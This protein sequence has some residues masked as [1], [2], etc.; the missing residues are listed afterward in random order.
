MKKAV[1]HSIEGLLVIALMLY[2]LFCL[3]FDKILIFYISA[4]PVWHDFLRSSLLQEYSKI[5]NES[6]QTI[7]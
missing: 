5:S 3:L 7:E 6:F 1:S 4:Y 2:K